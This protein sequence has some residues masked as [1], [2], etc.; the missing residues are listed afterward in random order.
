MPVIVTD[1]SVNYGDCCAL[2][3]PGTYEFMPGDITAVLG[4]NGAGKTTFIKALLGEVHY[5]GSVDLGDLGNHI[6]VQFQSNS[7][8]P[9]MKVRE[10]IRLVSGSAAG[11]VLDEGDKFAIRPL[12]N[13]QI[14]TLSG[15]EK[16]R[17]T[18]YLVLLHD[19][20]GYVFDELTSGLDFPSRQTLMALVRERTKNATV[21][22][23]THYFEEVEN[24]ASHVLI[25]DRGRSIFNGTP[26]HLF[27][28]YPHYSLI[29]Y[30]AS[31]KADFPSDAVLTIP[32]D[33]TK[34]AVMTRDTEDQGRKSATL[35]NAGV[36]FEVQPRCLYSAYTL[37]M[38]GQNGSLS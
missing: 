19:E 8:N 31:D 10:M 36:T 24:W 25:L 9:L 22:I 16:Q 20:Q 4:N 21:F 34:R 38:S 35:S 14:G 37:L 11:R 33:S 5:S 2:A 27:D 6:G 29:Q 3:L 28:L 1:L 7:Y 26:S 12:L 13:K 30:S 23:T 17:L 32:W 18:L 15:G